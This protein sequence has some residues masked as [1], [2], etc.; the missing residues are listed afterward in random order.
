MPARSHVKVD[1]AAPQGR[2]G[3]LKLAGTVRRGVVGLQRAVRANEKL[4]IVAAS[5]CIMSISHTALRPV[6]PV[7]AKVRRCLQQPLPRTECAIRYP[8]HFGV[9]NV[10][11]LSESPR[12]RCLMSMVASACRAS[13][14]AQQLWAPRCPPMLWHGS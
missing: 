13:V 4:L 6:L 7:F 10:Y 3:P 12:R 2:S 11:F 14:L 5:S 8:E 1:K 9:E